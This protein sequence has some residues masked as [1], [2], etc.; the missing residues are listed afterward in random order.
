MAFKPIAKEAERLR[1]RIA[2]LEG[3]L[4]AAQKKEAEAAWAKA[5]AQ[6]SLRHERDLHD[7]TK[8]SLHDERASRIL[9]EDRHAALLT[10][11]T[12][13]NG[14]PVEAKHR[15]WR[16]KDISRDGKGAIDGCAIVPIESEA[17]H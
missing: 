1:A 11:M 2:T 13:K 10:Q 14:A 16:V 9:A 8:A 4:K 15:G 7:S 5:D 3:E 12:R 6:S 17:K